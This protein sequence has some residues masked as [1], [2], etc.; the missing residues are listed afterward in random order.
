[1]TNTANTT[2]LNKQNTNEYKYF[3]YPVMDSLAKAI[4][5]DGFTTATFLLARTIYSDNIA[6]RST[7]YAIGANVLISTVSAF[8]SY[9]VRTYFREELE[10]P[11]IGGAI[12]G[13][14]K[15]GFR[16]F[17]NNKQISFQTIKAGAINNFLYEKGNDINQVANN[18]S[19][20]IGFTLIVESIDG[21]FTNNGIDNLNNDIKSGFAAGGI[22][23]FFIYSGIYEAV[24]DSLRKSYDLF[25]NKIEN[26][27]DF[28]FV[29]SAF[30][31]DTIIGEL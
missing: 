7:Y 17:L 28:S 29:G 21:Y 8:P 15:Y 4:S 24:K 6:T 23:S 26:Y 2:Q 14:I 30:D 25:S 31:I 1:M 19:D 13:A 11:Y 18:T 22:A 3:S 5:I 16:E 12:G 20:G 10:N 9:L 27:T